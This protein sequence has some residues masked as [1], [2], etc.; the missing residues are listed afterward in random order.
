MHE[1]K[2]LRSLQRNVLGINTLAVSVAL[3]LGGIG[4]FAIE[5]ADHKEEFDSH[6]QAEAQTI[7]G[8]TEKQTA[9]TLQTVPLENKELTFQVWLKNGPLLLQTNEPA[10]LLPLVPLQQLGFTSDTVKGE[11]IRKFALQS[12]DGRVVVQV[13]ERFEEHAAE[14][15]SLLLYFWIPAA[16]PLL[17]SMA[18]VWWLQR[19]SSRS[20]EALAHLLHSH[21]LLDPRPVDIAATTHEMEPVVDEVNSLFQRANNA[22]LTEQRFTAMAAHELRTP[23]AGIKAQAQIA[24]MAHSDAELQDALRAL[25]GGINRASHVFEQLFDLAH[26]ESL[27]QDITSRFAN[28]ELVTVFHQVMDDL[29]GK[30]TVKQIAVTKDFSQ[31]YV[32]GLDFA[33]YLL[34]RN[35][36]ANALLYTPARG[37]VAVSA[38]K[39]SQVVVLSVDDSG[40]GI[41]KNARTD[42]FERFN[43]LG[44]NG[45]DGVGLGLSIVLQIVK[46]HR[47]QIN[48]LDSPLGGLRVQITLPAVA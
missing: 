34:L 31:G 41:P 9:S 3:I 15:L 4:A 8:F 21:N 25:V 23:W 2:R 48:L 38:Q 26:M 6:L 47:G 35:L 32:H 30:A 42:A 33:I 22:I 46:M 1:I 18:A 27:S 20:L 13:A 28:I 7:L 40:P 19:R 24:Q 10:N 11:D 12:N 44:R 45:A 39:G 14:F 37:H 29:K 5:H 43:R 36:L 17:L 16:L